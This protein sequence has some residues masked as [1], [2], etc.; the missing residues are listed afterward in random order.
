MRERESSRPFVL[1]PVSA[2]CQQP[3]KFGVVHMQ[4]DSNDLII[5][6]DFTLRDVNGGQNVR[7]VFTHTYFTGIYFICCSWLIS[8]SID[9]DEYRFIRIEEET[10]TA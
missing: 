8:H 7:S 3:T 4:R 2:R 5:P 9:G 10:K 6:A 1:L